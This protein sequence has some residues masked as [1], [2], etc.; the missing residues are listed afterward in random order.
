MRWVSYRP[1]RRALRVVHR[2][3]V[4]GAVLAATGGFLMVPDGAGA[5]AATSNST[6][7]RSGHLVVDTA[8]LVSGSDLVLG[9]P[10]S[11]PW[12]S[13]PVG[14][15]TLGAAVWA[16]G[17]Y[18]AQLNRYDTFP[19]LKSAGQLGIPGLLKMTAAT[20]YT[21]RVGLYD[22]QL[23][24]SGG[25]M[26]ATSYVDATKDRFVIEV[27][28]ADSN[29]TQTVDLK[30][31]QSRTPITYASGS[32]AALAETFTTPYTLPKGTTTT[33][34][35]AAIT[36]SGT[37][38][39]ATV[40]DG[41]TVRLAFKP[42]TDG[43]FRI[44]AAVPAYTSGSI[45]DVA[46]AALTGATNGSAST[47]ASAHRSWWHSFWAATAPM[48]IISSDGTGEYMQ[49]LRAL[50]MYTTAS[51]QR[52][53]V[54]ATHGAVI[55]LFSSFQDKADWAQ[56]HFWH[57]NQRMR[58]S[59][60]FGSGM[61][62]FNRPYIDLYE[63]RLA[64]M[65]A[66]TQSH[67][68]NA[69]GGAV[70]GACIPELLRID[71]T[72]DGSPAYTAEQGCT[73]SDAYTNRIMSSGAEVAYNIWLQYKY[74][75]DAA[76]LTAGWPLM[77]AVTRF[78]MDFA[79]PSSPANGKVHMTPSYALEF[80]GS[81]TDP[82]T[83]IAAIHTLFPIAAQAAVLQGDTTFAA[84]LRTALPTFVDQPIT[85]KNGSTVLARAAVGA[86]SGN[87]QNA[88]LEPIWP[89]GQ[90]GDGALSTIIDD[91]SSALSYVGPGWHH[92][93]S[94]SQDFSGTESYTG[95]AGE[96]VSYTFSGSAVQWQG[97]KQNNLGIIK[98]Y[99]DGA[100]EATVDQYSS[101]NV[102]Q[103]ALWTK[104]G[105]PSGQH[106]IQLVA[107][108]TKN[109]SSTGTYLL[110]DALKTARDKSIALATYTNATFDHTN[111]D[112]AM[113]ATWAARLGAADEVKTQLVNGTKEFQIY[114]NGFSHYTKGT[115]P[116]SATSYYDEW[117]GVVATSLQEAAVQDYDGLVKIAPAWP[118]TWDLTGSVVIPGGH[119]VDVE[120]RSGLVQMVGIEAKSTETLQ[121]KNPW[122][123][124][125]VTVAD[126]MVAGSSTSS[127]SVMNISVLSG[128]S[129]RIERKLVPVSGITYAAVGGSAAAQARTLGTRTLGL[130]KSV[131]TL[132]DDT[133]PRLVTTGSG[134][135]RGST[136]AGNIN[137]TESFTKTTGDSISYTFTG[138][139]VLWLGSK[140]PN[141]GITGVYLD[142][143][144]QTTVDQYG[145]A[146]VPQQSLWSK[147]GLTPGE[148]TI[149]LAATGTK[150]I[151]STSTYLELDAFRSGAST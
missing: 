106:T 126:E 123:G 139:S 23:V 31:W 42:K 145:P 101:A 9:S 20:D 38:A 43:S 4:T 102:A 73:D 47:F 115:Q 86:A 29:L 39:S 57:F 92:S 117:N 90:Y 55:R 124:S 48:K 82:A 138:T 21:G 49:N 58:T 137:T 70:A 1:H 60:N 89:W 17:G 24:E 97:S 6:A 150:N 61:A 151:N 28:G 44:V 78:Y 132:I 41:L 69:A 136:A 64:A 54:P 91:A 80:T 30:L 135:T 103:Q 36:T 100:L 104:T 129:Y 142:G 11:Q 75:N 33:G 68:K 112:W 62:S 53:T 148:H 118:S 127:A 119:T 66:W 46:S 96:T 87:Q 120:V 12:Q 3:V 16:A 25:G 40:V 141:L 109:T 105:L 37:G 71:G 133:D 95:T 113:D 19:D 108:G 10:A 14:N 121:V 52:G 27:T 77:K 45:G 59:A 5:R 131:S 34:A 8:K 94:I 146:T 93:T 128:H 56:D 50:Q 107:T 114:P 125:E 7:W 83:D 144:L 74:T 143:A 116:T 147:T 35:L 79:K 32:T 2:L 76:V 140:Q 22:G 149:K 99:L 88:E 130:G 63:S 18:T 51:S 72:G 13:M 110:I 15:G 26:T 122:P 98:V 85:T 81:A 67:L 134:W 65:T 111:Y 84:Q